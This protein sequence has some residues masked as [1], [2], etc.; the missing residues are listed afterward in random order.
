MNRWLM[1]AT[2]LRESLLLILAGRIRD[3]ARQHLQK[4]LVDTFGELDAHGERNH[5]L[6][7]GEIV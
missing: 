2:D 4:S 1:Q 6:S 3:L 5:K 7:Q